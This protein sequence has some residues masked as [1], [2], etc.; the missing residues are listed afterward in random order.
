VHLSC[1]TS[2][3]VLTYLEEQGEDLTLLYE[4]I[5]LPVEFLRD[6]SY[7]L[8]APDMEMVLETIL[9]FKPDPQNLLLQK[10]GHQGPQLRTWGVLDSVLKMMPRPQ[11]VFYQ[12]EQFLSYFISPKPPIENFRRTED[13]VSFDLPLP[14]E[15]YPRVS[16]YLKAALEALPLYVGQPLAKCHWREIHFELS[17][18][19]QQNS[20]MAEDQNRQ[21]SPELFQNLID[22]LQTKQSEKEDLHLQIRDLEEKLKTYEKKA[23]STSAAASPSEADL[24]WTDFT[25]T[26]SSEQQKEN[27]QYILGQNL[28]R[29]HDYMVRAQQLITMLAAQGKMSPS[30]KEAMRRVDWDFVKSQYPLTVTESMAIVRKNYDSKH[31]HS[32]QASTELM[33]QERFP[34][35]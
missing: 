31:T 28:A 29:L 4:Q 22:D 2:N 25:L 11:E 30:V 27:P 8:Q 14:S 15:L 35:V 18:Q 13:S 23:A 24:T 1:K 10:A 5:A 12:P 21:I 33:L 3:A 16:T 9:K 20:L 17:W 19:T 34:Y 6:P 26:T 7:W 32:T